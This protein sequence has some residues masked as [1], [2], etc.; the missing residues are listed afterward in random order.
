MRDGGHPGHQSGGCPHLTSRGGQLVGPLVCL[1][2]RHVVV[3]R[4]GLVTERGEERGLVHDRE[5]GGQVAHR[6]AAQLERL[7][8]GRY[9]TGLAGGGDRVLVGR[10][11]TSGLLEMGRDEGTAVSAF[12]GGPGHLLV[13]AAPQWQAGVCVQGVADQRVPEVEG[14]RIRAGKDEIDLTQRAAGCRRCAH[15]WPPPAGPG[16]AGRAWR[17]SWSRSGPHPGA[18]AGPPQP[19][20]GPASGPAGHAGAG[21]V[22]LVTAVRAREPGPA[23]AGG[24]G[25]ARPPPQPGGPGAAT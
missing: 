22:K 17:W 23:P 10:P 18:A 21:W 13:Q 11:G 19:A 5:P 12:G 24:A 14:D 9:G 1:G 20:A 2:C 25:D 16:P 4:R 3:G 15:G 7:A 8:M 6:P